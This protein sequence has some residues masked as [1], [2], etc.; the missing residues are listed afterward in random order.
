MAKATAPVTPE[1]KGRAADHID[2]EVI[3]G[4]GNPPAPSAERRTADEKETGRVTTSELLETGQAPA[5]R[6]ASATQTPHLPPESAAVPASLRSPSSSL[7]AGSGITSSSIDP[8]ELRT[9]DPE[10]ALHHLRGSLHS[11]HTILAN[12]NHYSS[13]PIGLVERLIARSV[14]SLSVI[15]AKV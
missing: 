10:Q 15:R 4:P 9:Q 14:T 2:V 7:P 12:T 5:V 8:S 3:K 11:L 13:L 1:F 6:G